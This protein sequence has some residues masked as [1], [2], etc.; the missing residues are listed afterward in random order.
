[1]KKKYCFFINYRVDCFFRP[2]FFC[3]GGGRYYVLNLQVCFKNN[4]F[5][6][7][8]RCLLWYNYPV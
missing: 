2:A 5:P 4:C 3:R 8:L 7:D 1:M 6:V